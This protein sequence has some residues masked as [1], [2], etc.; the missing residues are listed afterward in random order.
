MQISENL[1]PFQ[2]ILAYYRSEFQYKNFLA[3]ENRLKW[4][5]IFFYPNAYFK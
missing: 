4:I 1:N 2:S 5:E 3:N